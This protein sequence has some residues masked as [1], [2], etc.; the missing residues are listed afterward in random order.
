MDKK[1]IDTHTHTHTHTHTLEH[2]SVI[3]NEILLYAA[4]WMGI[5]KTLSEVKQRKINII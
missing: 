4:T 5:K 3:K 1:D 2:Y